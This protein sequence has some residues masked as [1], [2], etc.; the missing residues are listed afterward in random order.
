M[1]AVRRYFVLWLSELG[2]CFLVLRRKAGSKT[3]ASLF[4][5]LG[6]HIAIASRAD[7]VMFT[8]RLVLSSAMTWTEK[9]ACV[10]NLPHLHTRA[11]PAACCC[12]GAAAVLRSVL[13]LLLQLPMALS[14]LL[15]TCTEKTKEKKERHQ[16]QRN[17]RTSGR[18]FSQTI[19]FLGRQLR[20]EKG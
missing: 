13:V 5:F 1:L 12:Y 19:N 8:S 7:A 17:Q 16:K 18:F 4:V 10:A 9:N 15:I 6:G 2:L 3:K 14:S 11:L 20:A